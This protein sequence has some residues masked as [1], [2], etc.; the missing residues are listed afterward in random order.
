MSE[1]YDKISEILSDPENIKLISEI[2][3]GF[4]KSNE[5]NGNNDSEKSLEIINTIASSDNENTGGKDF[6]KISKILDDIIGSGNI[7]TSIGLISAIRPYMSSHRREN[8]DTVIKL[9][10]A[11]K[12]ISNSNISD[13][14]KLLNLV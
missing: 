6:S 1:A 4:M 11:L 10:R 2:A 12:L 8:A 14:G 5:D 7:D 13:I 3:Q 9:L